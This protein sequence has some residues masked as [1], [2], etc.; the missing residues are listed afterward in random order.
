MA[1]GLDTAACRTASAAI[2]PDGP[3]SWL[4]APMVANRLTRL[5]TEAV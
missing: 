3:A 1:P 5:Q 2:P 4:L